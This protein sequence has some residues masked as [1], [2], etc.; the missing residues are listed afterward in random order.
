MSAGC[1]KLCAWWSVIGAF[2]YFTL[3]MMVARRNYSVLQ[4]KF[5]FD[6]VGTK[7]TN[8]WEATEDKLNDTLHKM[9][10]MV[11]VMIISSVS[12]FG[13]GFFFAKREEKLAAAEAEAREKDYGLI[14]G[15]DGVQA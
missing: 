15:D 1:C 11:I 12:C 3:A 14:F 7:G 5:G 2:M 4:E 10:V 9:W 8:E 6:I 13:L